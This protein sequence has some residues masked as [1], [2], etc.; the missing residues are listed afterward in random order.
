ME[1]WISHNSPLGKFYTNEDGINI[2]SYGNDQRWPDLQA[3]IKA[4]QVTI[5]PFKDSR[6][7][8]DSDAQRATM[9]ILSQI[10]GLEKKCLRPLLAL[11]K[12]ENEE[13]RALLN[14]RLR[15]IDQLRAKL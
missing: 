12:G 8:A 10:E 5:I 6:L 15:K 2:Q 11:S 3:K 14:D 13:E 7:A 4:N 1:T 9:D